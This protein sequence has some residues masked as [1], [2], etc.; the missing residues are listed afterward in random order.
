M[1]GRFCFFTYNNKLQLSNL[2][3]Q[4]WQQHLY[5]S[6]PSAAVCRLGCWA[7][8]VISQSGAQTRT[9]R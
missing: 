8:G 6:V 5:I 9:D 4:P 1:F 3:M 2:I 7:G